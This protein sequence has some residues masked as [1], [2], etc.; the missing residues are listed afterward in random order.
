MRNRTLSYRALLIVGLTLL[1]IVY[2]IPS[3]VSDLPQFWK[4]YLPTQRVHLGLDLQGGTHLVMTVDVQ[5]ALAQRTAAL[6]AGG[7][8]AP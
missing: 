3:L 6:T 8:L 4:D 7:G 1:A 5:K 2:L